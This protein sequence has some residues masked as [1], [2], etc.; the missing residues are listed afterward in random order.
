MT[1]PR[2]Q[3]HSWTETADARRCTKCGR[4]GVPVKSSKKRP[5]RPRKA[6]WHYW[7]TRWAGD[8]RPYREL[9]PYPGDCGPEGGPPA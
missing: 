5:G 2:G 3:R 6:V 1:T 7:R 4:E 9:S 8:G